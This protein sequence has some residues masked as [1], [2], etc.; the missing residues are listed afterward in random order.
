MSEKIETAKREI[1]ILTHHDAISGTIP[2][3]TED[4]YL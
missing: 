3:S 1:A 2:E 4:D